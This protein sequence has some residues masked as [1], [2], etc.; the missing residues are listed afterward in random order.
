MCQS[1]D[2]NFCINLHRL[3]SIVSFE[4]GYSCQQLQTSIQGQK[5][6][7][8]RKFQV[9]SDI[10]AEAVF[11]AYLRSV[12]ATRSTD[13]CLNV[14]LSS[15]LNNSSDY[16]PSRSGCAAAI[17]VFGALLF[18]FWRDFTDPPPQNEQKKNACPNRQASGRQIRGY[19]SIT[20]CPSLSRRGVTPPP[21]PE[22][23]TR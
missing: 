14:T 6:P 3:I 23:T 21:K 13:D 15:K 18:F 4:K 2:L 9:L 16:S 1:S 8:R 12:I 20:T 19:L 5:K 11:V 7:K 22:E 17:I 10:R